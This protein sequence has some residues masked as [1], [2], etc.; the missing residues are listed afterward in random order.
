[1][2]AASVPAAA[3]AASAPPVAAASA[4]VPQVLRRSATLKRP[5]G[6]KDQVTHLRTTATSSTAVRHFF[7]GLGLVDDTLVVIVQEE[8]VGGVEF[9]LVDDL[10]E[11]GWGRGWVKAAYLSDFEAY[12]ITPQEASGR[13]APPLDVWTASASTARG[14]G[15]GPGS[16]GGGGLSPPRGGGLSPGPGAT[17]PT[18]RSAS[19][20]HAPRSGGVGEAGCLQR[21]ILG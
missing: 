5:E 7:N 1:M 20:R 11:S 14:R 16:G 17:T 13:P 8:T 9:A 18:G 6:D 3:A 21:R 12:M 10:S 19:G 4:A 2:A 15:L